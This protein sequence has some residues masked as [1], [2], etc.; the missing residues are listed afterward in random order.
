MKPSVRLLPLLCAVAVGAFAMRAMAIA[1]GAGAARAAS[2]KPAPDRVGAAPAETPDAEPDADT[3]D[4]PDPATPDGD[5]PAEACVPEFDIAEQ[6]GLSQYE[7]TV[8]RRL[9]ERREA[10]DARERDIDTRAQTLAAA[11]VRLDEQI[12][13]LKVLED[14]LET[15]LEEL[16][17]E[18]EEEILALVKVYESMKAKDAARIFNTLEDQLMLDIADRMKPANVAAVLASMAPDR[19][20]KLTELMAAKAALPKTAEDLKDRVDA[21]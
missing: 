13:E 10:L 21:T 17:K 1:E 20:R 12:A 3:P 4:T 18:S 5:A 16:D 2:A 11:E 14:S 8:L 9:A 6:A 7:I 15:L 19:A